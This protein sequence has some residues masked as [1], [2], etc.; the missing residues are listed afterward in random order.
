VS[1]IWPDIPELQGVPEVLRS[2]IWMKAYSIALSRRTTWVLGLISLTGFALMFGSLGYLVVGVIGAIVG[3]MTGTGI[4][5][6]FLVRVVLEWQARRLVPEVRATLGCPMVAV[7]SGSNMPQ[8][9]SVRK[10]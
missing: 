7:S 2:G 4:G 3:A 1:Q 10:E 5:I 6:A 8:A 9:D